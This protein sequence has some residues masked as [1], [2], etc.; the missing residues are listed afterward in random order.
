MAFDALSNSK[1]LMH[2]VEMAKSFNQLITSM[3][4][5]VIEEKAVK[6]LR[7]FRLCVLHENQFST[8]FP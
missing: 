1:L 4:I 8:L 5:S 2:G 7:S 3:A 6:T